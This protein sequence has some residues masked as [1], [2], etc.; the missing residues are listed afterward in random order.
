VHLTDTHIGPPDSRPYGADTAGNVRA[1]AERV[2]QMAL[3]PAA[4][5]LSGDLADGDDA[6]AYRHLRTL[7]DESFG[8]F[9]VPVLLALGNH[10]RRRAFRSVFL[11]GH[12]AGAPEEQ[13]WYHSREVA[14]VR[15]VVLDSCLPGR[16]HGWLGDTQLAWLE[17]ELEQ[18]AP[19]GHVV[20]IHHPAV[21]RGVPRPD[22]YLLLDRDAFGAVLDRYRPLAV[23][24]GHSHVATAAVFGGTLH[25]AAPATAYLLDPSIRA[26]G[27][28]VEGAGF[29]LCTVRQGRLVVNTVLLPGPQRE[30]YRHVPAAA[31]AAAAPAAAAAQP[32]EVGR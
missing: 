14:G 1:V 10:D 32:A 23:L 9:G 16:V 21:P 11:G 7:L 8:P 26:G 6:A 2:R 20:V 24:C 31:P 29:N 28:A 12:A 5:V 4:I 19:L 17:A 25:V 13:P 22:D 30:L 18:P 15:F 27:R 3:D